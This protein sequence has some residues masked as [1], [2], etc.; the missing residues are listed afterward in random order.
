MR[1][2]R[3]WGMTSLAFIAVKPSK[4][5]TM[6]HS[7]YCSLSRHQEE[8]RYRV[9]ERGK[10]CGERRN[11]GLAHGYTSDDTLPTVLEAVNNFV[12]EELR[13]MFCIKE[14]KRQCV[15]QWQQAQLA[16]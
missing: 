12:C 15:V 14:T 4:P 8:R 7:L 13:R 3:L 11:G 9:E 5:L 16:K 1:N 10:N 2:V 6:Q